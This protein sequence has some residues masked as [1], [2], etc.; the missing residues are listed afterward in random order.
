MLTIRMYKEEADAEAAAEAEEAGDAEADGEDAS[1]D[2]E[3]SD[4]S[5]RSKLATQAGHV[6]SGE[7]N[8]DGKT[9]GRDSDGAQVAKAGLSG[10]SK[11]C[12]AAHCYSTDAVQDYGHCSLARR[13][14]V[15][16]GEGARGR[17]RDARDQP[18]GG[19]RGAQGPRCRR[20][21]AGGEGREGGRQRGVAASRSTER[22][23]ACVS[24]VR[25][26]RACRMYS[27]CVSLLA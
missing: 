20:D 25:I 11:S 4:E 27:V 22:C 17:H 21:G 15:D 23:R 19:R 26:G 10:P 14:Q 13:D 18:Q 6:K 1:A 5:A 16:E 3:S 8:Q 9:Q 12:V 24:A 2:T 7:T